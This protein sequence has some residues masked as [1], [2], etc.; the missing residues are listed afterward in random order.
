MIKGA[1]MIGQYS[2]L[3]NFFPI[4]SQTSDSDKHFILASRLLV[5]EVR[6]SYSYF[7]IGSY[8]GGSLTP[9]LMDDRCTA[10]LSVDERERQQP[11]ERGLKFDYAGITHQ[12]MIDELKSC[13]FDTYK[14]QTFDGSIDAYRPINEQAF[15]IAF[16]DGEHTDFA[17]FRDFLWT[18]PLMR[19][20][21]IVMFHDSTIIYK[22]LRLIQLYLRKSG[23]RF[24]FM[25]KAGS[26]MSGFFLGEFSEVDLIGRYGPEENPDDFF[27]FAETTMI[28][29]LILN[30][31]KVDFS[32][33]V[34]PPKILTA[35]NR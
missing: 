15:D 24:K 8:L 19:P 22:S 1:H 16:I 14:L 21:A 20:D 13:G 29:Y 6:S 32:V 4:E 2:P 33:S 28:H 10:L 25:K 7:E 18:L 27:D 9:F 5:T 17:C 12:T 30:R 3:Q 26:E 31:A 34:E 23:V 11:D 35:F